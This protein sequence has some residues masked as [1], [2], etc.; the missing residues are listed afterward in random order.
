MTKKCGEGGAG[1]NPVQDLD[2]GLGLARIATLDLGLVSDQLLH[3]NARILICI[4]S[5]KGGL[6]MSILHH[7][8]NEQSP[9]LILRK[10]IL[11]HLDSVTILY[12]NCNNGLRTDTQ[13]DRQTHISKC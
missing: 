2:L 12:P 6:E 9:T 7:K 3:H 8:I 10:C 5:W 1:D 11:R 13:I 4:I